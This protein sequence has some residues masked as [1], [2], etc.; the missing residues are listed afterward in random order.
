[1]DKLTFNGKITTIFHDFNGK[2]STI[3]L[4]HGKNEVT[5]TRPMTK[6]YEW[7]IK[8][9][10]EVKSGDYIDVIIIKKELLGD[11]DGNNNL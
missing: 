10:E 9:G 3:Y 4:N 8:S 1:M 6:K 11:K 5:I 2:K 7:Q